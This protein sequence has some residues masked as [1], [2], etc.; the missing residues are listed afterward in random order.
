MKKYLQIILI[1]LLANLGFSQTSKT[2]HNKLGVTV[3]YTLSKIGNDVNQATGTNFSKYKLH[4][5]V[6]NSSSKFWAYNDINSISSKNV[7]SGILNRDDEKYCRNGSFSQI[8]HFCIEDNCTDFPRYDNV[9]AP[10]QVI[11]P[12]STQE[13]EKIFLYPTDLAG[14]P[15]IEWTSWGF[16]EMKTNPTDNQNKTIY[17]KLLESPTNITNKKTI[18]DHDA[19]YTNVSS[20]SN[21]KK[22]EYY[23]YGLEGY[24]KDF[25]QAIIYYEKAIKEGD[26]YTAHIFRTL[27]HMYKDGEGV[28]QN[29]QIALDY[30]KKACDLNP[31]LCTAYIQLKVKLKLN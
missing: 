7:K 13:C 21:R 15:E 2:I 20:V 12:S 4:L 16:V 14:E 5:T 22:G 10:H 25:S 29:N 9:A 23:Q 17:K 27:G 1:V 3:S 8:D 24:S 26:E 6:Q 28:A 11:C 19:K 30:F 18:N 31:K